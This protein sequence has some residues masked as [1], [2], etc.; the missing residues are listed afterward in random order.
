[1]LIRSLANWQRV[2]A[3]AATVVLLPLVPAGAITFRN[4]WGGIQNGITSPVGN[5]DGATATSIKINWSDLNLEPG[6]KTSVAT[7][8]RDY[9]L[10]LGEKDP[11]KP[12][13]NTF[14]PPGLF[15]GTRVKI[16]VDKRNERIIVTVSLKGNF[17]AASPSQMTTILFQ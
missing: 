1:M 14:I 17:Q 10:E 2:L 9:D 12:N 5:T 6:N 11:K 4:T 8:T 13:K 16:K 7:L 15:A 3:A